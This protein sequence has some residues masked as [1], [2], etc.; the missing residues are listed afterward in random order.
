MTV[1]GAQ[2]PE[3]DADGGCLPG[4]VRP[5]EAVHLAR[6]DLQ[7]EMVE[8]PRPGP[9]SFTSPET[10]IAVLTETTSL[11]VRVPE[12]RRLHLQKTA[13]VPASNRAKGHLVT[14]LVQPES[15]L[16]L[17][18]REAAQRRGP[19]FARISLGFLTFAKSF[20]GSW[21]SANRGDRLV[22][23]RASGRAVASLNTVRRPSPAPCG[24]RRASR[25][26]PG[27]YRWR[28]R[29][30][31]G[32][33]RCSR[34]NLDGGRPIVEACPDRGRDREV[35]VRDRALTGQPRLDEVEGASHLKAARSL[36]V[37]SATAAANSSIRG[38]RPGGVEHHGLAAGQQTLGPGEQ[39]GVGALGPGRG[40]DPH[41][42]VRRA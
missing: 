12:V 15:S 9:K 30:T 23:A 3:Q 1:V 41:R 4:A 5:E 18:S 36:D 13:P 21:R 31:S 26:A 27:R 19:C 6:L 24:A 7:V 20:T 8:G 32:G 14:G 35:R 33:Q 25:R 11:H 39:L 29:S 28:T 22:I 16:P 34:V 37:R 17:T 38:S 40:V 10:A 42:G 2:Q